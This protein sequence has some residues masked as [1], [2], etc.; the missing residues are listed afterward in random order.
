[1]SCTELHQHCCTGK[2]IGIR[3]NRFGDFEGFDILSVEGHEHFFRGREAEVEELVRRAWMDRT[4]ISVHVEA[5]YPDWPASIVLRR[6]IDALHESPVLTRSR[7]S[8]PG[9]L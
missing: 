4:L 2:V 7:F 5:H 1:M 9:R 8:G 6:P 3:Y